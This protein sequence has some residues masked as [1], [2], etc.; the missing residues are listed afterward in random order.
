MLVALTDHEAGQTVSCNGRSVR[1]AGPVPAK[2]QILVRDIAAG[3]PVRMYGVTVARALRDLKAGQHL[4]TDNVEHAV[5]AV[6]GESVRQKTWTAPPIGPWKDRTFQGIH[7]ADGRVG[8][9]NVWIVV[10]LVFCENSNVLALRDAMAEELGYG[11]R[12]GYRNAVRRLLDLRRRGAGVEQIVC[13]PLEPEQAEDHRPF[14]HVDGLRFLVHNLGCGGTREDAAN[15]C[16]LI[17]GYI[18]H[19]NVAGATV[20]SLGCQNAEA[21]LLTENLAERRRDADKPLVLIEQQQ[22]QSE[23]DLMSQAIRQT[24]AGLMAA[25]EVRRAPASLDHLVVGVEC[26]ASDGF[27][28]ISANP[29]IGRCADMIV[30]LGGS[31]ILSEFPE[32]AGAEAD[33]IGR[34]VDHATA[35]R[36]SELM[37]DYQGRAE[38]VRTSFANNPSPGNIR[39]GLIT[40]AIKSLGAARKGGTS[41]VVDVIDYP[42]SVRKKGLTLLCTPGNDMESVTGLVGAGANV[43]LFSTGLGTP[44]GNAVAPV[45]KVASNTATA[46]RHPEM[47]DVDAGPIISGQQS[48]DE[49]AAR[50]LEATIAA[51]SGEPTAAQKLGQHDF[52]PWKRGVSL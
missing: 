31:V 42:Q 38:A 23:T 25:D 10:P 4:L 1:T 14:P 41:P 8:T 50:L 48:L 19:P 28:G 30:A 34:C 51:A 39:D 40:D 7:R 9:A 29:A 18:D 37:R 20:L 43:V 33:L 46:Q 26:G 35:E 21:R 44:T 22:T 16:G 15:L 11:P 45:L 32:L 52:L 17:A 3:Q 12:S 6:D 36:F 13:E 47:I 49:V 5:D 24:F 27:S 2:H